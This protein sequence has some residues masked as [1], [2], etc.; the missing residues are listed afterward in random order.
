MH[1]MFFRAQS[2]HIFA[3]ISAGALHFAFVLAIM[4]VYEGRLSFMRYI[5]FCG[6]ECAAIALGT[7]DFGGKIPEGQ[8]RDFMDAYIEIGGNHI[9]TAR[10]YGDFAGGVQGGSEQVIGRW[11]ED[12]RKRNSIVLGTKG[13]HPD[14]KAMRIGRLDRRN[15]LDDMQRSLD[16]LR[17]DCVDIYWLHR[18]DMS[19]PVQD[20]LESL[21]ELVERGMT[22]HVGV[23]NWKEGRILEA[24]SCAE[25]HGLVSIAANQPQFSLARQCVVEDETL[26]QMDAAMHAM[27]VEQAMPCVCFSSQAKGYLSKLALGEA[28][29]PDKA[30][31]RYH[32]PENTA[33]F[34]RAQELSRRTGLSIS[35]I[36]LAWLTSQ[37]FP[38]MPIAG[39]SKMEHFESIRD[40]GDALL[41]PEQRDWLRGM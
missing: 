4:K 28:A 34:S 5:E 9:D 12:R 23:S 40:A 35:A 36:A 29:L 37:P 38:C 21:T 15:L 14:P 22:K 17:T 13:G 7:M 30:R 24:L 32:F 33:V 3:M 11:M 10:I 41:A 16:N 2:A 39:V 27:H 25:K 1:R 31:R 18:D 8:A 26:C 6:K 19:R 20:I